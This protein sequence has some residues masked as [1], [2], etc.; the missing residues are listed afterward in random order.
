MGNP[1]FKFTLTHAVAGSI[2]IS[3]PDGW[4][5]AVLKLERHDEYH[6]LI[7]YFEGAFIFYGNNGV[8]NGGLDF[9]RA[10][11]RQYGFEAIITI[12]IQV[13]FDSGNNYSNIFNGQ[14]DLTGIQQVK[15]NK[16]EVPVIRNDFWTK[17]ILR[18]ETPVDIQ[19]TTTLDGSAC[20]NG[21]VINLNLSSQAITQSTQDTQEV[22]DDMG[23]DW[24]GT[25]AS[26]SPNIDF[27]QNQYVT[28][29]LDTNIIDE[30]TTRFHYGT[31][32][33]DDLPLP[34]FVLDY[35]GQY[36]FEISISMTFKNLQTGG[37]VHYEYTS[38]SVLSPTFQHAFRLYIQINDDA[39][40]EIPYTS[41]SQTVS[42]VTSTG[43]FT[44][45]SPGLDAWDNFYY[46]DTLNLAANDEVRI[47][48]R[49]ENGAKFYEQ[50]NG[51][52]ALL[53][54]PVI[55]GADNSNIQ[56]SGLVTDLP[57]QAV[58][59]PASDPVIPS[60]IKITASTTYK[61]T[62]APSFFVHDVGFKILN[63]ILDSSNPFYSKYFGGSHTL[64]TYPSDGCAQMFTLTRGLQLRD[65]SLTEKPFSISFSQFWKGLN[66]I[67][68]L[69]ICYET[70][71]NEVIRMED[72]AHFYDKTS[73]SVYIDDVRD[74]VREYDASRIF[75]LVEIGYNKGQ[76]ETAS[77][78]DDPQTKHTYATI[79]KKIKN[80]ITLFSDFI[81]A[82]LLIENTRRTTRIKSADYKY[83]DDT[84]IIAIKE[85]SDTSPNSFWPELSENFNSVTN[86]LS[87]ETR[88]NISLTPLR[89]LIRWYNYLSGCLQKYLTSSFKFTYGEG[90]TAM[91][92]DYSGSAPGMCYNKIADNL[93]EN[94][95]LSLSYNSVLGFLHLPDLFTINI[96]LSWEQYSAIRANHK[97]AIGISQTNTGH[98]KFFIKTLEYTIC[99]AK[100]KITCWP[101][102][103]M[104]IQVIDTTTDNICQ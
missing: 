97:K 53:F 95:D 92:S 52:S 89:N 54:Q 46:L 90:N 34:V 81:A 76:G 5:K 99:E 55:L 85:T 73:I 31:N 12:L 82:S 49:V 16:I 18:N 48:L 38:M 93:S 40:I 64:G 103:E 15:D 74:I 13:S 59:A 86:L 39:A 9:I 61:E 7:E 62:T 6:S 25:P 3:E 57:F 2:Q 63:R 66:P 96:D 21:N 33:R 65:Y 98:K 68:N 11:E 14:L 71:S 75:N 41:H 60:F 32:V 19:S 101:A 94:G 45:T 47:Y 24:T 77:G 8:V 56:W 50:Y 36:T 42:P 70:I 43:L 30:I 29:D 23:A 100:A 20:S 51:V 26:A 58:G 35:G 69:G 102:E 37:P 27:N 91:Q 28:F 87:P 10:I 83:D 67:F 44:P 4:K 22:R 72:K 104:V 17:F 84:F 80:T 79:I 78:L 1:I 88:Y